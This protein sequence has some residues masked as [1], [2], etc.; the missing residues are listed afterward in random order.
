M[1]KTRR[2]LCHKSNSQRFSDKKKYILKRTPQFANNEFG[3]RICYH[4]ERVA[5]TKLS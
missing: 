4:E 1:A 3:L 5:C 2:V